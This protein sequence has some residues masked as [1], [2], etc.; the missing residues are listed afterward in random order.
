[1]ADGLSTAGSL[2]ST[3]SPA[4]SAIPVAGSFLSLAGTVAGGLMQKAGAEKQAQQAAQARKDA[5]NKKTD[6]MRPEYLKKLTMDKMSALSDSPGIDFAKAQLEAQSAN[7]IRAIRDSSP[8]GAGTV[9]AISAALNQRNASEQRLAAD[10]LAY[11]NNN[12]NRVS[13][14]LEMLG[15]KGMQLE[16]RRDQWKRDGLQGAAALENAATA[17]K[18]TAANTILGGLT[19]TGAGISKI[20]QNQGYINALS[21]AYKDPAVALPVLGGGAKTEAPTDMTSGNTATPL[22]NSSNDI[23]TQDNVPDITALNSEFNDLLFKANSGMLNTV[24][25][26]RLRELRQQLKDYS[27]QGQ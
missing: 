26:A 17:N 5:L 18:M 7:Q 3:L 13:S 23:T 27:T 20:A 16:E 12:Q 21:N 9:A 11:K 14:D 1:M 19:S 24:E 2:V 6:A 25:Q 8:S 15:N 22:A 10:N 4:L